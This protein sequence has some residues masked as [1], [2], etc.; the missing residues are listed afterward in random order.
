M[1]KSQTEKNV[2]IVTLEVFV[3]NT[4]CG[5]VSQWGKGGQIR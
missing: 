3:K 5:W 2:I 4:H 1:D